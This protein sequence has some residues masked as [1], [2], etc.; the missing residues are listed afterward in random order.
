MIIAQKKRKE[1][2]NEIEIFEWSKQLRNANLNIIEDI[3][4]ASQNRTRYHLLSFS[5]RED[6][7]I[8]E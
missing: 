7:I 3:N 5:K 8:L 6:A 4:R 1:K 2:R